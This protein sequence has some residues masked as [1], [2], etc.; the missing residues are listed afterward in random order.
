MQK[1]KTQISDMFNTISNE[2][3]MLN[4][5]ITFGQHKKWKSKVF[6]LA[7]SQNPKLILDVA[8]GSMT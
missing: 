1:S 4:N 5:I 2:Y 7:K 3:D 6:K 8:T